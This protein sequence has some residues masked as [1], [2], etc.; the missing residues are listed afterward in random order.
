MSKRN[1]SNSRSN[2][3]EGHSDYESDVVTT[4]DNEFLDLKRKY[5]NQ[6]RNIY[7]EFALKFSDCF[8]HVF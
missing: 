6:I 2:T 3:D 5:L 4:Y 1:E 7:H 8:I